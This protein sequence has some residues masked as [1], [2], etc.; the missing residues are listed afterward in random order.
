MHMEIQY[1]TKVASHIVGANISFLFIGAGKVE[2][3]LGEKK[4]KKEKKI[5][6][7]PHAT[8][9][10]NS[11]WISEPIVKIEAIKCNLKKNR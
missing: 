3:L 4:K 9:K 2:Q 8:E 6:P 1:L 10:R 5:R 11:K 7:K